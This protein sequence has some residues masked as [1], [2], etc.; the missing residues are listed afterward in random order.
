MVRI[1]EMSNWNGSR[2]IPIIE[3]PK[4]NEGLK[5]VMQEILGSIVIYIG[6]REMTNV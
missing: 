3:K 6:D 5:T 2:I 4:W 1:I